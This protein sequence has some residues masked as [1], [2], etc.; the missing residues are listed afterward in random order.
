MVG[1]SQPALTQ[2]LAKLERQLGVTLFDRG[3]GGV[4]ATPAGRVLAQRSD[5]AFAHLA[6]ASRTAMRGI[7][8]PARPEQAMT[9]TQ[10]DAFLRLADAGSFTGAA[11]ATGLSQPAL[12]RAVRDLEQICGLPLVERRG[13]G[14][15]L[16]GA[17]RK[18][19]RGVRLAAK[20]IAAAIVETRPDLADGGSRVTLG[21][22][23]L[24]SAD[25]VPQALAA[26]YATAPH[27]TCDIVEGLVTEL[28]DPLRDGVI[29]LVVGTLSDD[30]PADIVQ[31]ALFTDTPVIAARAGHPLA[32]LPDPTG[33]DLARF[34][35]IVGRTGTPLRLQW[36]AMFGD[37]AAP[38]APFECGSVATITGLLRDTDCLTLQFPGPLAA[39][40][41]EAVLVTIGRPLARLAQPVGITTRLGWRPTQAQALLVDALTRAARR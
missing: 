26:L 7:T 23:P 29:D 1:L 21:V 13:R 37:A 17:G 25:L 2:G 10:L 35:W 22:M 39:A 18:L 33:A 6:H 24:C 8:G 32:G 9:A 12:H 27:V 19:V 5:M 16:T 36:Q 40:L 30:P 4:T 3:A 38:P 41:A 28:I 14:V 11:Q 34:P 31:Q 15:V 20:E